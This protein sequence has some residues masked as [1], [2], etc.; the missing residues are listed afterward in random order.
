M[1]APKLPARTSSSRLLLYSV[2]LVAFLLSLYVRIVPSWSVV[3]PAPGEVRLLDTDSYYHLRHTSF[4]VEHFPRVQRWDVG[5]NFP[6]GERSPH[7]GLFHLFVASLCLLLGGSS[8]SE[9]LIAVVLAWTPVGLYAASA[10]LLFRLTCSLSDARAAALTIAVW[11]LFPGLSLART[12]LGFADHHAAEMVLVLAT[13]LGLNAALCSPDASRL[14]RFVCALPLLVFQFAWSGAPLII[15]VVGG[16]LL[17]GLAS[18]LLRDGRCAVTARV[19]R[20]FG[21]ALAL[22]LWSAHWALPNAI[23]IERLYMPAVASSCG[24]LVLGIVASRLTPSTKLRRRV[25]VVALLMFAVVAASAVLFRLPPEFLKVL[26]E[27]KTAAVQEQQRVSLLQFLRLQGWLGV[28]GLFAAPLCWLA[29]RRLASFRSALVCATFTA[30]VTVGS[31][32]AHDYSYLPPPLLALAVALTVRAASSLWPSM[33]PHWAPL[34]GVGL[35]VLQIWPLGAAPNPFKAEPARLLQID[36]AW[37]AAMRWLRTST[38]EAKPSIGAKVSGWPGG[39]FAYPPGAYGVL[40]AW[41]F[42]NLVSALGRRVP[43]SSHSISRSGAEWLVSP[44]ES[45]SLERLCTTCSKG[46]SVRYVVL[47]AP[48]LAEHFVAHWG[49]SSMAGSQPTAILGALQSPDRAISL[50]GYGPAYE[51]SIALRLYANDANGL[52]HYRL[53]YQS[54]QLTWSSYRRSLADDE[55]KA[56][57]VI[58]V[59]APLASGAAA[60]R[61]RALLSTPLQPVE[62]DGALHYGH[63]VTASV[64]IFEVVQGAKVIGQGW[65]HAKVSVFLGLAARGA[66]LFVYRQ[67]SEASESGAFELVVPHA[68]RAGTALVVPDAPMQLLMTSADGAQQR[69]FRIEVSEE[70]VQSGAVVPLGDLRQAQ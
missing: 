69:T 47:S 19:S 55:A 11:S 17:V 62:I 20:D 56:S 42:G 31:L 64:K 5:T 22:G 45:V 39:R 9:E 70:A 26:L 52:Q 10:A 59:S 25:M 7:A 6:A 46:Q 24:L 15:A 54:E 23:M 2:A 21:A 1:P 30:A 8:P 33:V 49:Q 41:D 66:R 60:E 44:S 48:T 57:A 28:L 51:Q 67:T 32:F 18:D 14:K 36:D 27:T 63:A 16:A 12:L 13:L 58:R 37:V 3:F 38:P 34:T 4:A 29:A 50:L 53:V 61:A 35:G 43:L 40:S 65:P 68:S